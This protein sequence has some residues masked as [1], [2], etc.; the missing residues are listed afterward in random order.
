M[1]RAQKI[2]ELEA[3]IAQELK[4]PEFEEAWKETELEYQIKTMLVQ[5]RIQSGLTQKELAERSGIRQSNISRIE[6]GDAV[7]TI[8]TLAAIA[9]GIGKKLQIRMI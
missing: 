4:R 2:T 9:K 8:A 6:R 3:V 7:P 5:A 1:K